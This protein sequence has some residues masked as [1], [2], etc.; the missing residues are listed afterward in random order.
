MPVST[1]EGIF[2]DIITELPDIKATVILA[3]AIIVLAAI[4]RYIVISLSDGISK[5]SLAKLF[6]VLIRRLFSLYVLKLNY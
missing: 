3:I 4:A 6:L 5:R 1:E 2:S